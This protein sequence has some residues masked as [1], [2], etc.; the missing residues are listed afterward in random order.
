MFKSSKNSSPNA[1]AIV[2][3]ITEKFKELQTKKSNL[4][5]FVSDGASVVISRK[6]G[7]ATKLETNFPCYN[8]HWVRHRLALECAD[9]GD[10]YK[11][12]RNVEEILIELWRF[13]KNS[14]KR[15]HIYMK[16]TLSAKQ[17]DSLT[18]KEKLIL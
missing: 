11:F 2:S 16:V 7:V 17:F 4:K 8:I 6:G 9:T 18:E 13:F 10:D 15:L 1:N 14:S 5:V 3:C 12:I